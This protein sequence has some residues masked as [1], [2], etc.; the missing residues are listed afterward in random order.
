MSLTIN[1]QSPLITA[2][3]SPFDRVN[4]YREIFA[5]SSINKNLWIDLTKSDQNRLQLARKEYNRC[6]DAMHIG[7][8]RT[9]RIGQ[10]ASFVEKAAFAAFFGYKLFEFCQK[11]DDIGQ[12]CSMG[13]EVG[14]AALG[15]SQSPLGQISSFPNSLPKAVGQALSLFGL[16]TRAT[17]LSLDRC[18]S[19]NSQAQQHLRAVQMAHKEHLRLSAAEIDTLDQFAKLASRDEGE[20]HRALLEIFRSIKSP[21]K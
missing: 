21:K 7:E 1:E 11:P 6:K 18:K 9:N 5:N 8:N 4:H 14:I 17:D 20:N 3:H 10:I 12:L 2:T 16:G 15:M 13:F 19:M